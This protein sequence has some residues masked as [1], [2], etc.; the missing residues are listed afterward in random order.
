MAGSDEW[1]NLP[2]QNK[3]VYLP[4]A[5]TAVTDRRHI[6]LVCVSVFVTYSH[7][8]PSQKFEIG[9]LPMQEKPELL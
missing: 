7:F 8:H 2:R 3:N 9:R 5:E 4:K 6:S 1:T